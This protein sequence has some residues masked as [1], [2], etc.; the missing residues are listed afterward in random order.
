MAELSCSSIT[1]VGSRFWI[2]TCLA[3]FF[4]SAASNVY[5]KTACEL[6]TKPAVE[7]ALG[8]P[9]SNMSAKGNGACAADASGPG[10]EK[11]I[12]LVY[13][14]SVPGLRLPSPETWRSANYAVALSKNMSARD[15]P[16]VGEAAIWMFGNTPT[17][18]TG[19]LN[20][21]QSDILTFSLN[22]SGVSNE[23]DG[24]RSALMLANFALATANR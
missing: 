16:G 11:H 3:L 14:P 10:A 19:Q 20:V 6:L 7:A 21:F 22:I 8:V 9:I 24:L 13:L 2:R 5:G 1:G 18:P 12:L 4:V 17:G 23:E 15:V